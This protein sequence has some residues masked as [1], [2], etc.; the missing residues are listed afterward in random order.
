MMKYFRFHE[1]LNDFRYKKSSVNTVHEDE[2][3]VPR[4]VN[5]KLKTPQVTPSLWHVLYEGTDEIQ[6]KA[7]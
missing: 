5:L 2:I 7:D 3:A 6:I 1:H 4:I